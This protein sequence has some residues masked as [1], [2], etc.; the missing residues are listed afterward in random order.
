MPHL[1]RG[2]KIAARDRKTQ[3]DNGS[4]K[5]VAENRDQNKW[6]SGPSLRKQQIK[7]V[8]K[9]PSANSADGNSAATT[10]RER[11]LE[12]TRLRVNSGTNRLAESPR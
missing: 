3:I 11:V 1:A 9:K 12:N 7:L 10:A 8:R 6:R 5:T 2:L 4:R